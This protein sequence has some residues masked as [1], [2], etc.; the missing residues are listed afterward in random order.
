[1]RLL[2]LVLAIFILP[3]TSLATCDY[4]LDVKQNSDGSYTYS[5]ECH[6]ETGKNVKRVSL[7]GEKID[8][9]EQKMVLKDSQLFKHQERA[10]LW[11][12]TAN[13]I[14]DKLITYENSK[15]KDGWIQF[16]LGMTLAFASVWGAGQLSR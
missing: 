12:E 8:L 11:M 10:E 3:A 16:A 7:L 13:K 9:L 4:S 14:N 1:M 6:A 2:A 5:R 15:A